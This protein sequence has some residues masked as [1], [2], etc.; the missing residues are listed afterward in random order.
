MTDWLAR[1]R[2]L[3]PLVASYRDQGERDRHLPR[4]LFDAIRDAG[5]FSMWVPRSLG[6]SEVDPLTMLDVV[7][8]FARQ[9][10]SV[11]WNVMI[12]ANDGM[13]WAYLPHAAAVRLMAGNPSCV[14]AGSI[15][16]GAGTAVPGHDGFQV[17][18][19]WPFASGCMQADWLVGGCS[20]EGDGLHAFILPREACQIL[21]TWHTAG[22]RATGSH[23]FVADGV[24]VPEDQQWPYPRGRAC[25]PGPL[26]NTPFPNL[27]GP[28]IAAVALGIARD[29]IDTFVALAT[30]K[31][32]R[33]TGAILA[34]RESIHEKVGEAEAL[35]RSGR[36]FLVET[37]REAWACLA[38]GTPLDERQTALLR[39]AAATATR[40]AVQAVDLMF[41]FAG[42]SGVYESSRLERCLRDVH[43]VPQ[44]TIAGPAGFVIAGRCFLGVR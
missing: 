19:R 37:V 21:D 38:A 7:E 8:E 1:A 23:D 29:A 14:I 4:P 36:A 24:S 13:L 43:M 27:W 20:L 5:F 12:A 3:A 40:N 41:T 11:G 26:Y 9:D 39:L 6:G 25:E 10:G 16:A 28:N 33:V 32:N 15:L 30:G 2:S 34:E 22:L 17:S 35:L 44:H 18:G 31:R 42:T